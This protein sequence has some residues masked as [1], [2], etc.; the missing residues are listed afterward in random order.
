M[1]NSVTSKTIVLASTSASRQAQL[2][3]LGLPFVVAAPNCDETPL[4]GETALETAQRLAIA[5]AKSLQEAYPDALIIGGD[6]VALLHGQQLGKPLTI[7]AAQ[8]M[9]SQMSGQTIEFYSALCVFN[10]KSKVEHTHVDLT[11]VT[12]RT[13]SVEQ[14]S[15]YLEREP[16]A[17]FCAGAAKSEGLGMALIERIE[18]S[19]PNGLLGLPMLKLIEFLLV[20]GCSVL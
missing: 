19:D 15:R 9:L 14:I 10:S 3:R 4:V 8:A 6:Q 1:L 11:R 13:L 7:V 12:M 5:K 20:E 17:V 18:S 16:D 2:Q